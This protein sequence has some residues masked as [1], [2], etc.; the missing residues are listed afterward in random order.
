VATRKKKDLVIVESPAKAK[1]INKYLGTGYDVVAS[2]GHI[3]DLPKTRFGIDIENNWTPTYRV[4]KDR[5]DL[6]ATLKKQAQGANTVYLAPDPDR[7]GEAIAWHLK[8]SL[9]LK[10]EKI[11]R[12]TF[13]EI[14]KTAVQKAFDN[15]GAI[16]MDLVA[17]QEARRFLDRIVGYKLSPLLSNKL[18]Q[19][20]SAGRVQSVAVRLI[21]DREREIQAFKPEEYWRIAAVL[22]PEGFVAGQE[23]GV[24]SQ[25]SKAKGKAKLK[26]DA[27]PADGQADGQ[28][29][30]DEP[31]AKEEPQLPEG[32]FTAE[33]AEW[34]GEKFAASSQ[35]QVDEILKGLEGAQYVI[36]KIEQKDRQDRPPAPFT[37]STL[38]QGASLRLRFSAKRTMMTAQRLYEGVD[39][40]PEGSVALITYMRTDSTRLSDDAVKMAR[41]HISK[42]FGDIYLPDK[43]NV[44]AASKDAQGAHEAIRPTDVSYTPERV[45][46]YLPHDQLKLYTLIYQRFVA[47]QMKP[48]V[49]AVTSVEVRANQG[50]F[51]ASGR[52]LKFDGYRRVW[53]H[54]GKQEDVLL[55]PLK[56]QERLDLL[57]MRPTQHFT[58]PPPR[59]NE[60][61]L[62]KTLEKEGIGRP[63][64]Y[65]TIIS[66]IQERGYV[67]QKERRFYATE[68]GMKVNDILVD[69]FP[70][71]MDLK[72]TRQMEE[73]LDQIESKKYERNQ[74]LT[75]FYAPFS[76]AL[77]VAEVKMLA[78]AE[79]CPECGGAL[80]ERFSRFGKFFGC[81]NY[82]NCN[83]IKKKGS[84]GMTREPPKE[85]EHKCPECGSP[86]L[87]RSG[88]RGVFLGCSK[89]PECKTTMGL[90]AEGKPVQTSKPTEHVCEKCGK[91]MVLRE[92]RRGP[93][94]AC[95]G[96]PKCKNAKDV[97]AKGN[98]LQPIETGMS[99]EK[100]GSPMVVKKSFRG[101]F[102][103]CSAYP[104][105]RSTKKMPDDLK[106]KL[107]DVLPPTPKK[108]ELQVKI[109]DQCP[110]CGAAMKLR[111][112]RG[113]NY[114]LGC[115]KYPKCRGTKEVT[116][117]IL[118]QIHS[119]EPNK[120]PLDDA[121][122]A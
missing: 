51:R 45:A 121:G 27:P 113:G 58:E 1:T 42:S 115:T 23:S 55:P 5:K 21:V 39:L 122:A 17:A 29:A 102:L 3:R 66:K 87:Q 64:T 46:K 110:E 25:E 24:R 75:D 12:V 37:T 74:V 72:F 41:D 60:A 13:N 82:P 43:P 99:C 10:D 67:E 9:G 85:T 71:V 97:D 19:H 107:K 59:Y 50:M 6:I 119:A 77:K 105:C 32:A 98:P 80:Q 62:V 28:A 53:G 76:E 30:G 33:L 89:Y 104:K 86:M 69:N 83:Y 8:E 7:E 91:P 4:L 106:E 52:T 95:T 94:L 101:P 70:S 31:P 111:S 65:A 26:K 93:F 34:A 90:D 49:F 112:G 36:A 120:K 81:S 73:E 84:D 56:D 88:A 35:A 108:P 103:G 92:G 48:A 79:K 100:C 47:C 63:S 118:D 61:S 2:K 22:R 68:I 18:A 14:T 44:Y 16:D 15:A 116:P 57:E 109:E 54:H 11:R 38:Q 40:G 117:E 96:Y 20:L 78:D 114:F